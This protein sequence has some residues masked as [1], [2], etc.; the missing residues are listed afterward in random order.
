MKIQHVLIA[1]LVLDFLG[2]MAWNLSGQ[3][4]VDGFYIGV[5]TR[6]V[7]SLIA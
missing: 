2:F 4:P 1:V 5:I 7:I 3:L 6:F